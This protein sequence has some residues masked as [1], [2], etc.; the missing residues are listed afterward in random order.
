MIRNWYKIYSYSERV[1]TYL[2]RLF[3]EETPQG[4]A[5]FLEMLERRVAARLSDPAY[6]KQKRKEQLQFNADAAFARFRRHLIWRR[7]QWGGWAAAVILLMMGIGFIFHPQT[8]SPVVPVAVNTDLIPGGRKA[9][10]TLSD[11]QVVKL[12]DTIQDP[13]RT[14]EGILKID[15]LRIACNADTAE[16]SPMRNTYNKLS[17]PRGGEYQLTLSDGTQVWLN[18]ETELRFPLRFTGNERRVFLKGEAYF[19]VRNN[20]AKPFIVA[21]D[22]GEIRV[23]GTAFNI[24]AYGKESIAATLERGSISYQTDDLGEVM[25]RPGE[26]LTYSRGEKAPEVREVNT[27]LY[28]AWK[29][30]L[31]CFENQRLE[32]IMEILARWYDFHVIFETEELRQLEFSGT[33]DKYS[34]VRPLLD[35][36]ALGSRIN[37]NIRGDTIIVKR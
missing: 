20:Q 28:T 19:D 6:L 32:Q 23:Y 17:I 27:R 33:L 29:D 21:T 8:H 22:M 16:L 36:F 26:Q 12:G 15:S 14:E 37:F 2:K 9:I 24:S 10:L 1:T 35:L 34:D 11:G 4:E 7:I 31:F 25:I 13:I 5:R 30:H 3:T 18:S